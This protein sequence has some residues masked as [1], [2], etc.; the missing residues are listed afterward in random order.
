MAVSLSGLGF[1]LL[2]LAELTST[3]STADII[4]RADII[5]TQ[6]TNTAMNTGF[7]KLTGGIWLQ[8]YHLIWVQS[9][10]VGLCHTGKYYVE[11]RLSYEPSYGPLCIQAQEIPYVSQSV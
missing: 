9:C 8:K 11:K 2:V 3:M 1:L 7:D 10:N 4:D 6:T 5:F